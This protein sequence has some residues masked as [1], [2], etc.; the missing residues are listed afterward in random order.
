MMYK[1]LIRYISKGLGVS[2]TYSNDWKRTVG[3]LLEDNKEIT[4]WEVLDNKSHNFSDDISLIAWN[5][6]DGYWAN[7]LEELVNSGADTLAQKIQ[8]KQVKIIYER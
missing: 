8:R 4:Y 3:K 1:Y 5:G 6:T 2:L 7:V